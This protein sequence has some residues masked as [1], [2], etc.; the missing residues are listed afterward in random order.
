MTMSNL[1]LDV[2]QAGELKAAF[3]RGDWTSAEIKRA[4]EGDFLSRVLTVLRGQSE[5]TVVKHV[6]N[7]DADPLIPYPDWKVEE[8]KKRGQVVWDPSQFKLHLS[9]NQK[10]GKSIQGHKLRKE[11][12]SLPTENAN[13][14]D[15]LLAH[16]NL[17]PEDW[18][19]DENGKTRYI[20]FWGTVYRSSGGYLC[21]RYLCFDDGHWQAFARLYYLD[22]E[23][24]ASDPSLLRAS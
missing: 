6:I 23:F 10:A 16:P 15:Y 22:Y 20:F 3:R 21:V 9:S 2:D 8:H 5:I 17:I 13:L 1:M 11:L 12:E 24:D 14:L 7:G 4:C 18:K 19:K